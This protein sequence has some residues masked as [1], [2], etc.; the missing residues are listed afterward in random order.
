[1]SSKKSA[2]RYRP[3]LRG[4]AQQLMKWDIPPEVANM[5]DGRFKVSS[6]HSLHQAGISPLEANCFSCDAHSIIAFTKRG[7]SPEQAKMYR[8]LK[9]KSAKVVKLV[10]RGIRPDIANSYSPRF[11]ADAVIYFH[12]KNVP[13]RKIN[14]YD[15]L[16]P[17]LAAAKIVAL[18]QSGCLP[19]QA[20]TFLPKLPFRVVLDLARGKYNQ[21][22]SPHRRFGEHGV[23]SLYRAAI[24][25]SEAVRYPSHLTVEEVIGLHKMGCKS[26]VAA[27][28][29]RADGSKIVIL[30]KMG[31]PPK[32]ASR[33]LPVLNKFRRTI[34]FKK[35][36]SFQFVGAGSH[37]IVL[38]DT[39]TR[40]AYKFSPDLT[41]EIRLLKKMNSEHVIRLEREVLRGKI[42]IVQLRYV[43]GY[44]LD[45]LCQQ[46]P[47][48]IETEKVICYSSDIFEGLV[49]LHSQGIYHRDL[50]TGNIMIDT[51]DDNVIIIDLGLATDQPNAPRLGNRRYGGEND[52]QSLG[53]IVYKMVTGD[54]LFNDT[55]E[56]TG[57]IPSEVRDRREEVYHDP[58][59]LEE[60]LQEVD[61]NVQNPRVQEIIKTCLTACSRQ[62][63]TNFA[64][65]E[66]YNRLRDLFHIS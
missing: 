40:T 30:Y 12:S 15:S 51:V 20:R 66:V 27:Q 33:I 56:S 32:Q 9:S 10:K 1:M 18:M 43:Q 25:P 23:V 3:K 17:S 41:E 19:I 35:W 13:A 46:N 60:K 61:D 22:D 14:C 39:N 31:I 62:D 52:L 11:N 37:A 24:L 47:E 49:K 4:K 54:N 34:G 50:W 42:D 8:D 5:Y 59:L 55:D 16:F 63:N 44:S 53:Q 2:N 36:G 21:D 6:I 7:I 48:G 38:V 45:Y 57:V 58:N 29:K 26:E 65:D 28:Y 64:S